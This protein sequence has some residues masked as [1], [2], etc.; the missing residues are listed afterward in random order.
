[1]WSWNDAKNFT[2]DNWKT[3]AVG[4]AIGAGCAAT[5][6]IGCAVAVGAIAGAAI[7]GGS[8]LYN[9]RNGQATAGGFAK[10]VGIGVVTGGLSGAAGFGVGRLAGK[11]AYGS[12]RFGV[13]SKWFGNSSWG[14]NGPGKYNNFGKVKVGWSHRGTKKIGHAVFRIGFR[15]LGKKRHIDILRGPRLW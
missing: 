11:L 10:A 4:L 15:A 14:T 2:K 6:G 13:S 1:M 7:G 5:A 3:A 12:G 9:N 8:Y